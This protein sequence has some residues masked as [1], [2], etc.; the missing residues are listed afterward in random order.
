MRRLALLVTAV[1]LVSACNSA[2]NVTGGDTTTTAGSRDVVIAV[3][4]PFSGDDKPTGD[5]I[6]AGAKL[7]ASQLNAVGGIVGGPRKG[8]KIVIDDGFDDGNVPQRAVDNVL[9]VVDDARYVAFVGSGLSDAS[10]AAAPAASQAGLSYLAAYASSPKILDAARALKSVFV[11]PPTFPAYSFSV[12]DELLKAGFK[13][14]AIIHVPG[15]Y[16]DGITDYFVQRLKDKAVSVVANEVFQLKDPSVTTQLGRIKAAGPDSL[17]MVGLAPDDA[18]IV[19][20]ADQIQLKVPIYDPGGVTNR[21]SFLRD[22]G[23]LANGVVG[24]SPSDPAR[25]TPAAKALL[26]AYTA[27]TKESVLP[28]PAAFAYEGVQ[29]VAA[30]FAD[31]AAGRLDLSDHLHRIAI[32]DTGVG[33][34]KFAPDGSRVGGRLFIFT[35]V[36]GKPVFRAAYEQTGPTAVAPIPLDR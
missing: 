36:A 19:K 13:K 31:G 4:G 1:A 24:T 8:A 32:A 29:A 15:T 21:D 7:A 14:P 2:N 17:V 28:D 22:A 9:K 12:A 6:R 33:P 35:I 3:G 18:N 5:Q 30:G 26:S 20:Q 25:N 16:G 23:S 27:A 34:L 11:L 10:V